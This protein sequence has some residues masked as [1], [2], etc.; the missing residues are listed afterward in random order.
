MVAAPRHR[1]KRAGP[2]VAIDH[3]SSPG[4]EAFGPSLEMPPAPFLRPWRGH[5]RARPPAKPMGA[6]VRI[7]VPP[8]RFFFKKIR[9]IR[10]P[11][12]EAVSANSAGSA[13]ATEG[14][15]TVGCEP[16]RRPNLTQAV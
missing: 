12:A 4:A 6:R 10:V 16:R 15:A 11:S 5:T 13:S 9:S 14:I 2:L 3:L 1:L 7:R 8:L